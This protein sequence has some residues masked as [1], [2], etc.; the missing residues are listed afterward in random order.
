MN[1]PCDKCHQR[2]GTEQLN[3]G[4]TVCKQCHDDIREIFDTYRRKSCNMC[5]KYYITEACNECGQV[6]T[7]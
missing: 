5:G 4:E 3:N 6:I 2:V 1:T 7:N